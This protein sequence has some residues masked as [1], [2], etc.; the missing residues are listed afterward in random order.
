MI[1]WIT[2]CGW[3]WN[4]GWDSDLIPGIPVFAIDDK[5]LNP[6][7]FDAIW[8]T[9]ANDKQDCTA[10]GGIIQN[11]CVFDGSDWVVVG[12]ST[13]EELPLDTS[14][15]D[16]NLSGSDSNVQTAMET[17]DELG[18]V[19][20]TVDSVGDCTG[21]ACL[22]GTSGSGSKIELYQSGATLSEMC[23]SDTDAGNDTC[24]KF[25]GTFLRLYVNNTLQ[26][27]WP[28]SQFNLV[29]RETPANNIVDSTGNQIVIGG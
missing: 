15:F 16:I 5:P 29:D 21:G 1:V 24:F 18:G 11:L 6:D 26:Q 2:C 25:D 17:L 8:V 10:G 23:F 3:T 13:S 20:G 22:D 7:D 28:G 27:T 14:N 4:G 9:D 12:V 19:G